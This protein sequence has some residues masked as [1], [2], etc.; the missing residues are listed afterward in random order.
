MQLSCK[1][2]E[3][4]FN[5]TRQAQAHLVSPPGTDLGLA[6]AFTPT[7]RQIHPNATEECTQCV[8]GQG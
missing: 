1:T 7:A 8:S 5:Q 2:A 3:L 6:R 4:V